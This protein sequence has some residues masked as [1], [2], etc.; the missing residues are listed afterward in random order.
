M[1]ISYISKLPIS[2]ED[3]GLIALMVGDSAR[4]VTTPEKTYL[5]VKHPRPRSWRDPW[6]RPETSA[7]YTYSSGDLHEEDFDPDELEIIR[8]FKGG[9]PT[10]GHH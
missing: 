4:I 6:P 2:L 7:W 1:Y 9:K 8:T 5:A 10:R 3:V